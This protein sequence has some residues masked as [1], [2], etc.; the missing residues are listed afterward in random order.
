MRFVLIF[1]FRN[2][3]IKHQVQPHLSSTTLHKRR[4]LWTH[5][6]ILVLNYRSS[7][8]NAGQTT[9]LRRDW[10]TDERPRVCGW[11]NSG[12]EYG[13]MQV[14]AYFARTI[15]PT[16]ARVATGQYFIRVLP[17][18]NGMHAKKTKKKTNKWCVVLFFFNLTRKFWTSFGSRCTM[19]STASF[20][21]R[22]K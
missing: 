8:T 14:N 13:R 22:K 11:P 7:R 16:R 17:A 1:K 20:S 21:P 10:P 18:F 3:L 5:C 15:V 9:N 19:I 4:K 2:L 12:R 6:I